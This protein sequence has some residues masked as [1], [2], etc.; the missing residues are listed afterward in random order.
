MERLGFNS[1]GNERAAAAHSRRLSECRLLRPRDVT[2]ERRI[3]R[4]S[5][6]R[7]ARGGRGGEAYNMRMGDS[8]GC[9]STAM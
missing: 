2:G 8:H 9:V 4:I 6:A 1:G 7:T 5:L 3:R